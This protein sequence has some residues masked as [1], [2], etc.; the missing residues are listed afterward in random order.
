MHLV[1]L[2][3]VVVGS[4]VAVAVFL[5][6]VMIIWTIMGATVAFMLAFV[7]P[8]SFFLNLIHESPPCSSHLL[9]RGMAWSLLLASLV[10]S[11]ACT[12]ETVMH[13]VAGLGSCPD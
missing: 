5:D 9:Q 13:V 1:L 6:A 4:T 10:A 11:V 12:A 7:L 8:C 2:T 3:A